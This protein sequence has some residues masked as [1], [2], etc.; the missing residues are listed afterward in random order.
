MNKISK[1]VLPR[2]TEFVCQFY[3]YKG[4]A[5]IQ[6]KN[7]DAAVQAFQTEHELAQAEYG[8]TVPRV[9]FK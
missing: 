1:S 2:K 7:Y 5:L 3:H 9:S 6:L 4:L 8:I